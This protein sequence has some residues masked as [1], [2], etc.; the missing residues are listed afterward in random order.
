[1]IIII[2]ITAWTRPYGIPAEQT[3]HTPTNPLQQQPSG[4]N[5]NSGITPA[6]PLRHRHKPTHSRP[7]QRPRIATL[8]PISIAAAAAATSACQQVTT[9]TTLHNMVAQTHQS[10][11]KQGTFKE[12]RS[13]TA[14]HH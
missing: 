11:T 3:S 7:D 13:S 12:P 8:L 4:S 6:L 14:L 5:L 10:P 9:Q 1:L 2:I